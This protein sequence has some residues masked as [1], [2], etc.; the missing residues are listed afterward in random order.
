MQEK[1][2]K[3]HMYIALI[4]VVIGFIGVYLWQTALK[5]EDADDTSVS[6]SGQEQILKDISPKEAHELIKKHADNDNFIIFDVR[7]PAEFKSGRIENSINLDYYTKT[8]QK[9]LDKLDKEK[10]YLVYCRS[11]NRSG[12]TLPLMKKLNF[13]EAYN[14]TGGIG[15]W[16]SQKFPVVK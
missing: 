3:Q 15:V 5:A 2:R 13:H 8:F 7:T 10:T 16:Y 1:K 11:G 14:M 9:D 12:R 4:I 6:E